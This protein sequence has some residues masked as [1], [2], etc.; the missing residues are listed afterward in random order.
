MKTILFEFP[1]GFALLLLFA[2]AAAPA[3]SRTIITGTL[4]QPEQMAVRELQR[5]IAEAGEAAPVSV[6]FDRFDVPLEDG[7]IVFGSYGTNPLIRKYAPSAAGLGPEESLVCEKDI[8]GRR[9][10]FVCGGAPRGAVYAVYSFLRSAGYCFFIDSYQAPETFSPRLPR[11]AR[12]KPVFAKRG[13]LPWHNFLDGPTAWDP[14]DYR[15][16]IDDL[17]RTGGNIVAFHTYDSEPFAAYKENGR[18][19][20]G[21][22][23]LSSASS[24][25]GTV[26][27]PA[28]GFAFGTGRLFDTEYF[29]A[30][31]TLIPDADRAVEAEQKVMRDALSYAR[32]RGLETC[33]GFEIS[34]DPTRPE[35]RDGFIKR[36]NA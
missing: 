27:A 23:L 1:K 29:G 12:E 26:P 15:A 22:R 9:V 7:S 31:T 28:S 14:E 11:A 24:V 35:I 25:W 6:P 36:I 19:L 32:A 8:G 33:L 13:L 18:Y 3:F 10:F 17:V 30:Q 34:G 5:F 2:L 20:M 16:Y 21:S 4:S